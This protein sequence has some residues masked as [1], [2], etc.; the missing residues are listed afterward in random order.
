MYPSKES[1]RAN[2]KRKGHFE[3]LIQVLTAGFDPKSEHMDNLDKDY[4]NSGV[5]IL[6]KDEGRLIKLNMK[7]LKCSSKVKFSHM[8]AYQMEMGY[9]LALAPGDVVSVN[10]GFESV[11]GVF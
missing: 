6:S 3:S 8:L 10:P 9:D 4:K 1:P 5:F 2:N 7:N 11:L